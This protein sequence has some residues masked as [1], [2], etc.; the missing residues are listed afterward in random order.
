[1]TAKSVIS[2][3]RGS[4][5]S[6]AWAEGRVRAKTVMPVARRVRAGDGAKDLGVK[7]KMRRN[8]AMDADSTNDCARSQRGRDDARQDAADG[9]PACEARRTR[10]WRRA[11]RPQRAAIQASHEALFQVT[12]SSAVATALYLERDAQAARGEAADEVLARLRSPRG[13]RRS[14]TRNG[15]RGAF[16][17]ARVA[18][19]RIEETDEG[20][21]T[22]ALRVAA[23][24]TAARTGFRARRG[25]PARRARQAPP[26]SRAS[27]ADEAVLRRRVEVAVERA[28]TSVARVR[29]R[30]RGLGRGH[31][32]L[33]AVPGAEHAAD[34][35]RRRH[36][37]P[38]KDLVQIAQLPRT[39][40]RPVQQRQGQA[41]CPRAP[42]TRGSSG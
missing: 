11:T 8:Y 12:S 6:H 5:R 25:T 28:T 29:P 14:R 26:S 19:A 16:S 4:R 18:R 30:N 41:R 37:G 27:F 42:G 24:A 36:A 7:L 35:P 1:M 23:A 38:L 2:I 15:P 31:G 40:V 10:A 22:R 39:I 9:S 32:A 33:E 17:A 20:R 21:A 13:R 3:K 34:A